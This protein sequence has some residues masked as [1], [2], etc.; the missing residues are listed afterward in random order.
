ML[1]LHFGKEVER[2]TERGGE[3]GRLEI[4]HSTGTFPG[5]FLEYKSTHLHLGQQLYA[6]MLSW[7]PQLFTLL[8]SHC[9]IE[10]PFS[11]TAL[12]LGPCFIGS[13]Y[14]TYSLKN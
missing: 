7:K 12:G 2:L 13:R 1:K 10:F 14:E 3:G 11:L 5:N 6:D 4:P 9:P 8:Y